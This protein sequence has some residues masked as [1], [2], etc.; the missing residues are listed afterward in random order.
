MFR[1]DLE[2]LIAISFSASEL[3]KYAERWRVHTDRE[4]GSER[5]ARALVKALEGRGKL[6]TLVQSLRSHKPL[7]EWPEPPPSPTVP[8]APVIEE[9]SPEPGASEIEEAAEAEEAEEATPSIP[10]EPPREP[11]VDP[12][13][14]RQEDEAE[15]RHVRSAVRIAAFIAVAAVL[16]IAIG[17]TGMYFFHPGV[18]TSHPERAGLAKLAAALL[19]ERVGAVAFAC[20]APEGGDSARDVLRAAFAEC[21]SDEI[22]PGPKRRAPSVSPGVRLPPGPAPARPRPAPRR[23]STTQPGKSCLDG[24]QDGYNA[25]AATRCGAEPQSASEYESWQRCLHDCQSTRMRC[26][27]TCR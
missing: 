23:R 20:E 2:R 19:E 14:V 5:G 8:Q 3:S 27:L 24:C 7:V 4:G 25:C 6:A 9:E 26:R 22:R 17:A 13:F 11:L 15:E 10:S 18:Q 12:Y 1:R 21:G 16:G